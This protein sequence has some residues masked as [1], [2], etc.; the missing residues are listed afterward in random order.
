MN[1]PL[2]PRHETVGEINADVEARR[3]AKANGAAGEHATKKTEPKKKQPQAELLIE[4][5][6]DEHCTE[7]FHTTDSTAYSDVYVDGHR[8]THA[9]K[10]PG[11]RAWIKREYWNRR[12]GSPNSDAM[13]QATGVLEAIA[14][15]DGPVR[16]VHLRIAH[17]GYAI[18]LDLC[19]RNWEVVEIT[20]DGWQVIDEPPVRFQRKKKMLEIP[21]PEPGAD[22]KTLGG[23][24]DH[25]NLDP[26][27]D[28]F[29]LLASW[30]LGTLRGKGPFPVLGLS[31]EMGSAKTDTLYLLKQVVDPTKGGLRGPPK[32]DRDLFISAMNGYILA[33][34]NFSHVSSGLADSM[35][36]LATGAG[37]STRSLFTDDEEV[38]FDGQRPIAITAITEVATR[39]DLADRS[40]LVHL[41]SIPKEKRK[42]QEDVYAAFNKARPQIL[43]SLLDVVSHGLMRYPTTRPNTLPRMADFAKWMIACETAMWEAG[44]FIAAYEVS[45][46][47]AST[48]VLDADLVATTLLKWIKPRKHFDGTPT[49]L[50]RSLDAQ[51][52]DQQRRRKEW[53]KSAAALTNRLTRV[54]P[55]LRK[56]GVTIEDDRTDRQRIVRLAYERP[57]DDVLQE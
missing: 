51:L 33:F 11:Y 4:I 18:Y 24:C 35:C 7:L 43:G 54:A 26:D 42:L 53:P 52:D 22:I 45:Q 9:L 36:R 25:L 15:Y 6:T 57:D 28:G 56:A 31:G 40:L 17:C 41:K 3:K 1:N 49:G 27:E 29:K 2:L 8:E 23:L 55:A 48:N 20:E 32:D 47:Q 5:G 19:N 46:K 21:A 37:F 38:V 44:M 50:W 13:S 14:L 39:S 16:E 34:D 12:K 10:S 30:L